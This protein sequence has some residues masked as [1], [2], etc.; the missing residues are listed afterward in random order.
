VNRTAV[1][2]LPSSG[3]SGTLPP[4]QD[5]RGH[6]DDD[7]H[8]AGVNG[9]GP[10]TMRSAEPGDLDLLQRVERRDEDAFRSLF[11]RHAPHAHALALRVVRQPS[12]AEDAVQDAFLA[13]WRDAA[14]YDRGRG[15]VRAWLMQMVHNRAV[16]LVRREE[17]QRRRAE[18]PALIV[19]DDPVDRVIDDLGSEEEGARVREALAEL[20]AE[21]RRVIE[22]MYFEGLSQSRIAERLSIPLGTVKSR[23]VLGMRRLH[24]RLA[25]MER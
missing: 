1:L 19:L 16:D 17:S 4:V 7:A 5:D 11:R 14:S 24:A 13:L 15:S 23:T 3:G 18:R 2:P 22:L 21:Q 25:G 8:E 20:P 9:T 6:S 10:T 12:L